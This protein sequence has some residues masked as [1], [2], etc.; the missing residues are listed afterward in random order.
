VAQAAGAP[1]RR[2]SA[3]VV[4]LLVDLP[5]KDPEVGTGEIVFKTSHQPPLSDIPSTARRVSI[6][7]LFEKGPANSESCTLWG[8][9][10]PADDLLSENLSVSNRKSADK[11]I[12]RESYL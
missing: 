3:S 1:A 6:A 8:L 12:V 11:D 7:Y 9:H 5:V 2:D 4:G 10:A